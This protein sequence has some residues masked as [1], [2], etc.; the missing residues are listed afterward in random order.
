MKNVVLIDVLPFPG[1][2]GVITASE[3]RESQWRPL[4]AGPLS[5]PTGVTVYYSTQS[6]P[7]RPEVLSPNPPG[8]QPPAWSTTPPSDITTVRSL[9]IDFGISTLAPLDQFEL[10]WPM[11]A[12]LNAST[13]GQIAWNSFGISATL[14]DTNQPL[15]SAEPV[16]V[17]I[18]VQPI[19]PVAYGDRVW[20]DLNR[21]GIQDPNEPGINGVRVELYRD[22]GDNTPDP[23]TDTLVGFTITTGSGD[24][25]FSS[26]PPGNYFSVIFAPP[27]FRPSPAH[28]TTDANDSDGT[29]A[30][31]RGF[32]AAILPVTNLQTD[33][34]DQTWDLGMHQ[35]AAPLG[36]VGNYVWFDNSI[37]SGSYDPGEG[38]PNVP[39]Q[40]YSDTQTPGTSTPLA[41][42][43]SAANGTYLFSGLQPGLYRLHI[44]ASAFQSGGP[45]VGRSAIAE[46]FSGD[47]DV[48]QDGSS[49]DSPEVDGVSSGL[50]SLFIG[51]TP[52][53]DSG[54][55]GFLA[56]SDDD[57]DSAFDL[58]IDFGFQLPLTLGNRLFIDANRNGRYD[59]G[60]GTPDITVQLFL[61]SQDPQTDLPI[62]TQ[63]TNPDG[64]YLFTQLNPASYRLHVPA[65]HFQAGAP[66]HQLESVPGTSP[67]GD[68]NLG[69]DGLDDPLP[70]RNGISTAPITLTRS[71]LPTNATFETG[72]DFT[73]DDQNDANG[74]LTIDLGFRSV[75]P[76]LV[77]VGNLV[78]F[79]TNSNGHADPGE[80]LPGITVQLFP[81]GAN[82][83]TATPSPAPPPT[84]SAPTSSATCPK[85]ST[86]STSPPLSFN[87]APHCSA[88]APSQAQ[89][90]TPA[91]T[92]TSTKTASTPPIPTSPAS[93]VPTSSSHQ[94]PN[95]S[96]RGANGATTSISTT[97]TTITPTSPSTSASPPPSPSATSSS[98]TAMATAAPTP[99]KALPTS[100]SSSSPLSPSPSLIPL[101]P[102]P[103]PT[104]RADISSQ[105]SLPV[106]TCFTSRPGCSIPA[107]HSKPSSPS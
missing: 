71:A 79:D 27:T 56:T 23:N 95:P 10:V 18:A 21:D 64:R 103:P 85:A 75:D 37:D 55:T 24:Y 70:Q 96:T 74:N 38:L 90:A 73:S 76:L 104:L 83:Q 89:A 46:G 61:T 36:A 45:L 65:S 20:N 100:P 39:V 12:P 1:D 72:S 59:V 91:S 4:L 101:S 9:K 41:T 22:N 69:E 87:P 49:T 35:D 28:T 62:R 54:E 53:I 2:T 77:G 42:T 50:V 51:T 86:S 8:A 13:N 52:T 16:K 15:P 81:D 29:P 30:T 25:L 43:T 3:P 47:D 63:T 80:G 57:V 58:T 92:T 32:R 7:Q 11:R 66:L 105:T 68:D 67:T 48:G 33:E 31:V 106:S 14:A 97:P 5:A 84:P 102:P 78:F 60:E 19:V 88:C 107:H 40:L 82:P 34:I 93:P 98:S 26:M 44:P 94:T 6:N 17:G 99:P